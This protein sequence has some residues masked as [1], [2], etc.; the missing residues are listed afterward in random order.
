[1]PLETEKQSV[2]FTDEA[3]LALRRAVQRLESRLRRAVIE[4]SVR[5]RGFPVEVTGS[6]VERAARHSTFALRARPDIAAGFDPIPADEAL[7]EKL[8]LTEL[9]QSGRQRRNLTERMADAYTRVGIALA[10]GGILVPSLYV[11]Y[12]SL[13][14]DLPW[15]IGLLV[16]GTGI[17][18]AL[19]GVLMRA[20]L[21]KRPLA[22]LEDAREDRRR[23]LARFGGRKQ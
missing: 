18:M 2:V 4:E 8:L 21:A 14:R 13:S 6:D 11:L 7:R 5:Q 23:R 17:A 10:A 15:R 19:I 1:M 3:E 16:C 20:I 12:R 22:L 9:F